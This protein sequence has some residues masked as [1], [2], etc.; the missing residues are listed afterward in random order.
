M[1]APSYAKVFSEEEIDQLIEL[2]E[3]PGYRLFLERYP[4]VMNE[5]VEIMNVWL[6]NKQVA[7]EEYIKKF[8]DEETEKEDWQE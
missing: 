5:S 7:I 2:F 8:V 6:S 3:S 4:V 1:L